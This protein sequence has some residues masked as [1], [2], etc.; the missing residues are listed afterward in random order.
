[1]GIAVDSSGSAFITGATESTDFPVTTGAYQTAAPLLCVSGFPCYSSGQA[2]VSKLGPSGNTLL[3]STYL[4]GHGIVYQNTPTFL[5]THGDG[6]RGITVDTAGNVYVVGLASSTDFPVTAGVFQPQNNGTA[7]KASNAFITKLD[8]TLSTL[9]YST[10]LGGNSTA[11]PLPNSGTCFQ[12]DKGDGASSIVV[13]SSG[14]AYVA[15]GTYSTNFPTTPG[16]FQTANSGKIS[17][18]VT[19]I[20]PSASS[21][22]YST[23]LGGSGTPGTVAYGLAVDSSG[24]AYLAGATSSADLP[25]T[26]DAFQSSNKAAAHSAGNA[27]FS[28]FQHLTAHLHWGSKL[29]NCAR[30]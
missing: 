19:K 20:N 22:L 9:L 1:L 15:G 29:W 14:N 21:L 24:N 27:F 28:G 13:D 18:F 26:S 30:L 8:P 10:Y 17:A 12:C 16:A 11:T 7:N 6:G 2:F 5:Y 23:L 25:I 4:G 3:Y